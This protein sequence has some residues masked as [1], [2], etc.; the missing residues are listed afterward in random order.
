MMYT[1]IKIIL[2]DNWY[3]S[4]NVFTIDVYISTMVLT[5]NMSQ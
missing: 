4:C 5:L 1:N 3:F 2:K